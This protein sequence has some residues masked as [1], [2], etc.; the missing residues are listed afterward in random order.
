MLKAEDIKQEKL[1]DIDWKAELKNSKSPDNL[2]EPTTE[3]K[4]NLLD[5]LEGHLS[6]PLVFPV[7]AVST[8]PTHCADVPNTPAVRDDHQPCSQ[9]HIVHSAVSLN[10]PSSITKCGIPLDTCEAYNNL[11]LLWHDMAPSINSSDINIALQ[12]IELLVQMAGYYDSVPV[13]RIRLSNH[14]LLF[15]RELFKAILEDPPR[16][17]WLSIEL[18]CVAIFQE[19]LIHI[20][21]YSPRWPWKKV[22]MSDF[23][24]DVQNLITSKATSLKLIKAEVNAELFNSNI[25]VDGQDLSWGNLNKDTADTWFIVQTWRDWFCSAVSSIGQDKYK[26]G[27]VYRS[28]G[29]GSEPYLVRLF[30]HPGQELRHNAQCG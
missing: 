23:A 29:E 1:D 3:P 2:E 15:R 12:E 10:Q 13:T 5:R 8:P 20:V 11:F 21:G 26:M 6:S 9:E 30:L 28:M 4:V 22:Q 25:N 16:W 19:A 18:E 17:L 7:Q 14:L 27:K 24:Q